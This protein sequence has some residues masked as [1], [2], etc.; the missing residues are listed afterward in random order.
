[1]PLVQTGLLW[2]SSLD[3]EYGGGVGQAGS[4]SSKFTVFKISAL[5]RWVKLQDGMHSG[6]QGQRVTCVES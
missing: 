1:M 5:R 2:H 6:E 4:L 3:G